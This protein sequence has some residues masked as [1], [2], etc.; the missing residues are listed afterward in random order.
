MR[1]VTFPSLSL[2]GNTEIST[3]TPHARRDNPDAQWA[4]KIIISTHTP[5]AR[6]DIVIV[7]VISIKRTFQLTRLMR[8]VTCNICKH[9]LH[10]GSFQLTRLMRG[11]TSF[12]PVR[13]LNPTVFQLTR[14]MRGVTRPRTSVES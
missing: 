7:V 9:S 6:R 14:L 8:G 3:H 12:N 10:F 11:V 5:H 4:L 13:I 1:G 2:G